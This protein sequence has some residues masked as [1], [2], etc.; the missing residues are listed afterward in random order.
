M[1]ACARERDRE[2]EREGVCACVREIGR[3]RERV[4]VCVRER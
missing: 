2:G 3:E 4:Y 1:C